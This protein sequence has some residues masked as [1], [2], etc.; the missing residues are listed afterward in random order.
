MLTFWIHPASS[1]RVGKSNLNLSGVTNE[2]RCCTVSP[3]LSQSM[4][5]DVVAVWLR[6]IQPT[7]YIDFSS[8]F[9]AESV[10][11]HLPR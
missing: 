7:F 11:E 6:N 2:P 1:P 4:L 8:T 3:V 10:R 5:Q 9:A